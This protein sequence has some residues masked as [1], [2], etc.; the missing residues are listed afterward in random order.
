MEQQKERKVQLVTNT[1]G[2][3]DGSVSSSIGILYLDLFPRINKCHHAELFTV[4]CVNTTD[5]NQMRIDSI[6]KT[7]PNQHFCDVIIVNIVKIIKKN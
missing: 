6:T 3:D 5:T 7:Q 1:T 2:S 4:R